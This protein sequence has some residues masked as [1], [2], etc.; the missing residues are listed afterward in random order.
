MS[1]PVQIR[2]AT[3]NDADAIVAGNLA[4]ALETEARGLDLAVLRAGVET[5]LRDPGRGTYWV[6]TRDGR[7]VGQML[8]TL[9]W[10]DWRNG[11]FWWIQS[12]FVAADQRNTGVY[13]ALHAHVETAARAHGGVCGL[14][15]YVERENAAAQRVYQRMGMDETHYHLYEIDWSGQPAAVATGAGESTS[16]G[17]IEIGTKEST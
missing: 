10:S 9:E 2:Q 16:A 1:K 11:W 4:M 15:L 6:A 7:I 12:V 13:R 17:R 3:L 5:V 14:R 8:I